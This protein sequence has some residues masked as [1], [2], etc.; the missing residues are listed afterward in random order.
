MGLSK[1]LTPISKIKFKAK[2]IRTSIKTKPAIR[3]VMSKIRV[4]ALP[5]AVTK[6]KILTTPLLG[7]D[8]L[9]APKALTIS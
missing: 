6:K 8:A 9:R 1:L 3:A 4:S 5:L 2:L 7:P